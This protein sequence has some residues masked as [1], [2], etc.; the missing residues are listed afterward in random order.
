MQRPAAGQAFDGDDLAQAD[1]FCGQQAAARRGIVHQ[2][3]AGAA[4]AHTATQLGADK[5]KRFTQ[6]VEQLLALPVGGDGAHLA[7]D[8]QVH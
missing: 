1:V 6:H 5:A 4:Q 7:V 3:G 2:H 8:V